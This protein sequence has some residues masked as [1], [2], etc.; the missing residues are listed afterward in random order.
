M[1]D[2]SQVPLPRC[3]QCRKPVDQLNMMR[4]FDTRSIA[5]WVFCHGEMEKVRVPDEI[6]MV[7]D[8][9]TIQL[10]DCFQEKALPEPPALL[11]YTA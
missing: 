7:S 1:I 10:T 8:L 2:L 6:L 11:Q 3:A 9:S 5:I 4:E